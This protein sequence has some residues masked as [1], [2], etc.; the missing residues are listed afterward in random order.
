MSKKGGRE[1]TVSKKEVGEDTVYWRATTTIKRSPAYL[2]DVFYSKFDDL[3]KQKVVPLSE[4]VVLKEFYDFR[5]AYG[6]I[7]GVAIVSSRDN[8]FMQSIHIDGNT[9]TLYQRSV[10]GVLPDRKVRL[11]PTPCKNSHFQRDTFASPNSLPPLTLFLTQPTQ[12]NL[13]LPL[14]LTMTLEVSFPKRYFNIDFSY[15]FS[16]LQFS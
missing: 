8:C 12:T 7:R 4:F 6:R 13:S 14:S 2:I 9:R 10:P 15:S 3:I 16:A 11:F 5:I 1:I